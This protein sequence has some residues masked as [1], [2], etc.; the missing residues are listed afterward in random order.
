MTND[1]TTNES[2]AD[3]LTITLGGEEYRYGRDPDSHPAA[4]RTLAVHH[5]ITRLLQ[6]L[7]GATYDTGRVDPA[8]AEMAV[9]VL[10]EAFQAGER[11][12]EEVGDTQF[13]VEGPDALT[14]DR[15]DDVAE[16]IAPVAEAVFDV[17]VGVEPAPAASAPSV[18]DFLP[19][20]TGRRGS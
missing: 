19:V 12:R 15:R 4:F 20:D 1:D 6:R 5:C 7:D 18:G 2:P 10:T 11:L 17:D 16:H 9:D 8:A 13:L 3:E 14:E